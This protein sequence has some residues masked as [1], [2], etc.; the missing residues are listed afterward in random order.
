MA[1][2]ERKKVCVVGGGPA[3]VMAA[4]MFARRGLST[5]LLEAQEDFDTANKF[6]ASSMECIRSISPD[7]LTM[8][9]EMPLFIV[10][11]KS[12]TLTWPDPV[13]QSWSAQFNKWRLGLTNN[14]FSASFVNEEAHKKGVRAMK[15]RHQMYFQWNYIWEGIMHQFAKI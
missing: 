1:S 13:L 7:C 15:L 6:H 3:G 2:T 11:G 5:V 14:T 4:Y 12:Q 9:T 10:G 8:V